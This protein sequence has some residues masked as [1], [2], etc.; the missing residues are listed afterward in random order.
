MLILHRQWQWILASIGKEFL[1]FPIGN[2]MGST[3]ILFINKKALI[4]VIGVSLENYV[5]FV[6]IAYRSSSQT[7]YVIGARF[8]K[9]IKRQIHMLFS[10]PKSHRYL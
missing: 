6:H 2:C 9:A 10:R 1:K 5:N 7:A 8:L 3:Q 4:R